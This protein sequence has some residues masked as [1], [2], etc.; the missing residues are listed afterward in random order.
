[1]QCAMGRRLVVVVVMMVVMVGSC[2]RDYGLWLREGS[3]SVEVTRVES[4]TDAG[5]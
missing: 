5:G 1:M 4:L 3:R 2:R